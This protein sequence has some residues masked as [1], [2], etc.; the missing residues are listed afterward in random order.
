MAVVTELNYFVLDAAT[1]SEELAD[2]AKRFATLLGIDPIDLEAVRQRIGSGD[3]MKTRVLEALEILRSSSVLARRD[4]V[5]ATRI[6]AEAM[7]I[8][9]IV[10]DDATRRRAVARL[11]D[12]H[13]K[14]KRI[15]DDLKEGPHAKKLPRHY[16][17]IRKRQFNESRIFDAE[18]HSI[19]CSASGFAELTEI[20]KLTESYLET[21]AFPKNE[22]HIAQ[23]WEEHDAILELIASNES[24]S[25]ENIL[26]AVLDHVVLAVRRMLEDDRLGT[27]L[28]VRPRGDRPNDNSSAYRLIPEIEIDDLK[29]GP[30][31]RPVE[32]RVLIPGKRQ[33]AVI[34]KKEQKGKT[35]DEWCSDL[36]PSERIQFEELCGIVKSYD[37]EQSELAPLRRFNLYLQVKYP[38]RFVGFVA[39]PNPSAPFRVEI[40]CAENSIV[41]ANELL[42]EFRVHANGRGSSCRITRV[43]A[44]SG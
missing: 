7:M 33:E 41:K 43:S 25:P 14:L 2:A 37:D 18:F 19:I 1:K 32:D 34:M 6:L 36:T 10:G 27:T 40:I 16:A 15:I 22:H 28:P 23:V 9:A 35:V 11:R 42:S 26:Q 3:G 20:V 31:Q 39:D 38:G 13:K 44:S 12:A 29:E 4:E 21:N 5:L 24:V 17:E 8:S 30:L